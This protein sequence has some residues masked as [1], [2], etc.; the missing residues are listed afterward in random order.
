MR[1]LT[2]SIGVFLL[3][4]GVSFAQCPTDRTVTA[5][6]SSFCGSGS[7]N[8]NVSSTDAG[9]TYTLRDDSDNSVVAGP[10]VG[11]GG[12][13]SFVTGTLTTTTTFNVLANQNACDFE[14][15]TTATITVNPL[16]VI[17]CNLS[18]T[19]VCTADTL[20]FKGSGGVTYLWSNGVT[21]STDQIQTASFTYVLTGWDALGCSNQDSVTV[22]VDSIP[23]VQAIAS[24][25]TVCDGDMVTLSGAG[26]QSYA[27]SDPMISDG[28]AFTTDSVGTFI[29]T[30]TGTDGNG[31]FASAQAVITVNAKPLTPVLDSSYYYYCDGDQ[32]DNITLTP[33]IG[34]IHWYADSSYKTQ[35]SLNGT[36]VP[37]SIL[38]TSWY[39]AIEELEGCFSEA[40]IA[41]VEFGSLPTVDAGADIFHDAGVSVPLNATATGHVSSNWTP[42]EVV[43]DSTS[44]IT[45]ANPV[46]I[47]AMIVTVTAD[48]GCTASDTVLLKQSIVVSNFLSPNNDGQNDTWRIH[49]LSSLQGCKVALYD[50]LGVELLNTTSYDNT[51]DGSNNGSPLAD[52]AY[53]Y[54]VECTDYQ[55]AG[56][57]T[58]IR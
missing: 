2:T 36:C 50:G 9:A 25:I 26:A 14:L 29:H 31:C 40:V 22:T 3:A 49:P 42:S 17:Q 33:N 23:D 1:K 20:F 55:D 7:T 37:S 35:L 57:V 47:T 8:I 30:V 21:D 12:G 39:Y 34:T 44:L 41:T 38:G 18:D 56:A 6:L 32:A 4:L 27:W 48:S 58:L 16:P 54:V 43:D 10:L 28:A 24:A 52:G 15:T 46:E 11:N 19:S 45:N 53:Y 5:V 51:W 13:L